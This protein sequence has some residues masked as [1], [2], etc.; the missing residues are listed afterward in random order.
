M[1]I[2]IKLET[3]NAAFCT[4]GDVAKALEKLSDK[5]LHLSWLDVSGKILDTNGNTV[6]TI[7]VTK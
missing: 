3:G 5:F 6:G 4:R 2:I 7:E 1:N